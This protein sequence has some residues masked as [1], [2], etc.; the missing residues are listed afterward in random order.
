MSV[1]FQIRREMWTAEFRVFWVIVRSEES[2]IVH[3]VHG[4]RQMAFSWKYLQIRR[5]IY[6]DLIVLH[7]NGGRI[8]VSFG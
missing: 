6:T 2:F 5:E 7:I 1:E 3:S 8:E 4:I